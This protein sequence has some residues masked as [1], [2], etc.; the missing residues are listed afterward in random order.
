[1]NRWILFV[2]LLPFS[3]WAQDSPQYTACS[4]KANTQAEMT[5]CAGEEAK[6]VDEEL[7][8]TYRRLLSKVRDNPLATAKIKSSQRAW[9]AYRDAYIAAAYPAKDKQ[10]EYGSMYPMEVA[11]LEAKLTRRQIGALQDLLSRYEP[12]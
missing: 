6:R 11:L 7:N 2:G 9:I 5:M 12:Q 10:A 4:N 1:M 8:Q 3:S